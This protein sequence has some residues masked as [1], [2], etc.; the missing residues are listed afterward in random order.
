MAPRDVPGPKATACAPAAVWSRCC[1]STSVNDPD[2]N[3]DPEPSVMVVGATG[4][5][6]TVISTASNCELVMVTAMPGLTKK[7]PSNWT[8]SMVLSAVS[9]R[10][11]ASLTARRLPPVTCG[12]WIS[13]LLPGPSARTVLAADRVRGAWISTRLPGPSARTEPVADWVTAPLIRRMP[14]PVAAK[15]PSLTCEPAVSFSRSPGASAITAPRLV[16]PSESVPMPAIVCGDSCTTV[17]VVRNPPSSAKKSGALRR[18]LP[19]PEIVAPSARIRLGVRSTLFGLSTMLP[20][21]TTSPR[22]RRAR[23]VARWNW[24]RGFSMCSEAASC[25]AVP[26]WTVYA[27]VRPRKTSLLMPGTTAG[28]QLAALLHSPSTG[29]AHETGV[30]PALTEP[31][32]ATRDTMATALPRG[33]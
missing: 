9:N 27:P 23:L 22:T 4:S 14:P 19:V 28:L 16:R 11:E 7:S 8:E 25:V 31:A 18:M 21:L 24:A 26:N 10:T 32:R 15:R 33:S 13:M 20:W 5:C 29:A 3:T 2:S 30:V 17:S 6:S 12:P 1:S